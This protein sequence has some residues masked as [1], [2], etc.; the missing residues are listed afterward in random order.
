MALPLAAFAIPGAIQGVL[1]L[2]QLIAGS[3]LRPKRPEYEIPEAAQEEM[4]ASR[5]QRFGRMPGINYAQQRVDQNAASSQYRLQKGA[6]NSSQ[7]LSG[8]AGI[9]LNSNIAARGLMEAE[10][11]DQIRRDAIFRRSLGV[12]AG[13]QDKKWELNKFQPYQDKARTKAA[14]IGGGL[15]NISGGIGQS[16]SGL[17]SGQ[18]LQGQQGAGG[19]VPG[20]GESTPLWMKFMQLGQR[21]AT[22]QSLPQLGLKSLQSIGLQQLPQLSFGLQSQMPQLGVPTYNYDNQP[23]GD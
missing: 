2:G 18:M 17:L 8:L 16:L 13:Y 20:K 22:P 15:Q 21:P 7:L 3:S 23:Y 11:G 5:M 6:T 19:Q 14:L 12:M 10:A 9:Q 4:A 1:G